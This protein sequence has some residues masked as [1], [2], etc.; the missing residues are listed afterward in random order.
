[1]FGLTDIFIDTEWVAYMSET[2][3]STRR[4]LWKG[5]K[6]LGT[7]DWAVDLQSF[8]YDYNHDDDDGGFWLDTPPTAGPPPD[9]GGADYKNLDDIPTDAVDYCKNVYILGALKHN[10]DDAMAHYNN[11]INGGYEDKFNTYADAVVKSGNNAIEKFMFTESGDYFDCKV[12]ENVQCCAY[13]HHIHTTPSEQAKY[14][15]YCGDYDCG[16]DPSCERYQNCHLSPPTFHEISVGCTDWSKRNEDPPQYDY[17]QY[18]MATCE[19]TMRPDKEDDFWKAFSLDTGIDKSNVEFKTVERLPCKPSAS[20][21]QC[22]NANHDVNFPVTHDYTRADI[23]NP[24]DLVKQIQNGVNSLGNQITDAISRLKAGTFVGSSFDI[25]DAVSLPVQMVTDAIDQMQ[26]ISDKI[27][28]QN[29]E[30]RK[31]IILAFVTAIFLFIPVAGEV[32]SSLIGVATI[33]RIASIAGVVGNAALDIY[34][35][36]DDPDNAALAIVSLVFEP[37]A[38]L[39]FGKIAK[40]ARIRRGMK[41]ED[42]KA[43][44]GGK[45][46]AKLEKIDNIRSTCRR[47]IKRAVLEWDLPMSSAYNVTSRNAW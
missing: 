12:M 11:L 19:W 43:L 26:T 14:C 5:H 27:D 39:D 18:N 45:A 3:K 30:K 36:V 46:G 9:C 28:E 23:P 1:M 29:A 34:S 42:V 22:A 15:M 6:F 20:E 40:A 13:C 31:G 21:E 2:T 4:D 32:A 47:K 38:L 33:A 35:I 37:L 25:V 7:I 17:G 8:D 16:W 44:S 41:A 24:E 10:L